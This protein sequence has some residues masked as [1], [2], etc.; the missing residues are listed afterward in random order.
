MV[1]FYPDDIWTGPLRWTAVSP[2]D[3]ILSELDCP[4]IVSFS[5]L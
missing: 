1:G 4:E 3:A 5:C 2:V